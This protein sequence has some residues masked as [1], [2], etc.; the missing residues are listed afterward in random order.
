MS[1]RKA[2]SRVAAATF[3]LLAAFPVLAQKS[4]DRLRIAINEF[5]PGI[6]PYE[7]TLDELSRVY[8][9]VP[10]ATEPR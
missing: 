2:A 9:G 7:L 4:Q 10:P 5:V 6:N 8:R 3:A 1:G